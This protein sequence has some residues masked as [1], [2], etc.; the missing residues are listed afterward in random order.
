MARQVK[1]KGIIISRV[2]FGEADRILTW[3]TLDNGKIKTIAKAVRKST[4]K[5]AGGVELF[6]VSE[7]C[8]VLGKGDINTLTSSRLI[9]HFGNI[10]KDLERTQMAYELIR[11][12]NK[13]TEDNTEPAYFDLLELALQALDDFAISPGIT[14]LWF[15]MRLLR[16]AGHM[17]NL[18]TDA[19]GKKL[20]VDRKYYFEIEHM[21]FRTSPERQ[22]DFGADH[23]KFLRLGFSSASP[24]V[25]Q[26]V[27][28][29]P[30]LTVPVQPL[31]G[32]MLA[33]F[34]RL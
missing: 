21:R 10:V 26:R 14:K 20:S 3:L 33:S 34:V 16:L 12:L 11:I 9:K 7:I 13:A 24:N 28:A 8:Y 27:S 32:A 29:A 6:S 22:G 31:V 5:L 17:P 23:I 30:Q 19:S 2:D 4:S 25:I 18:E 1:T 15:D